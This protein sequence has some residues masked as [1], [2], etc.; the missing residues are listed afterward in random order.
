MSGLRASDK[1]D[2]QPNSAV[3]GSRVEDA[4]GLPSA[5]QRELSLGVALIK[6]REDR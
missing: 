5:R 2:G 1:L 4:A 6:E 3:E